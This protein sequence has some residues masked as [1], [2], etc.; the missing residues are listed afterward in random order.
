MRVKIFSLILLLTCLSCTLCCIEEDANREALTST[1]T[2]TIIPT[3]TP[4]LTPTPT[5][6]SLNLTEII[7]RVEEVRGLD[8]LYEIPHHKTTKEGLL[9]RYNVTDDGSDDILLKALFMV[10]RED[11]LDEAEAAYKSETVMAYYDIEKK[12]IVI[13]ME[14][15]DEFE[16]IYAHEYLHAIQDQHFNL[17][18]VIGQS[19][20]DSSMAAK[21][22]VE[23]DALLTYDLYQG[24]KPSGLTMAISK[25]YDDV[26]RRT[27]EEFRTFPTTKGKFFVIQLYGAGGD[28]WAFVNEAYYNLPTTTEMILHP[29]KYTEGE[30]GVNM[31]A[32]EIELDGWNMTIEDTMGELFIRTMLSDHISSGNASTSA[33]GWGGDRLVLYQNETDY[34]FFFNISWDSSEDAEE[35]VEGYSKMMESVKGTKIVEEDG[36]IEWVVEEDEWISLIMIND[37]LNRTVISGSSNQEVLNAS[38][39]VV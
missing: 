3:F 17:T 23:G 28:G 14:Y 26:T 35:F 11:A 30:E 18:R 19:T 4:E 21:A 7:E 15:E 33:S 27:L 9:E 36:M 16:K 38:M 2:I 25:V 24:K 1:P 20:F 37:S 34:L 10:E 31:T 5:T 13:A 6:E 39:E 22:L 29:D 12:E 32:T 8:L